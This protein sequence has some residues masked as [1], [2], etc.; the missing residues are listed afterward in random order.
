MNPTPL[1]LARAALAEVDAPRCG[2]LIDGEYPCALPA[3][4]FPGC[5]VE[6]DYHIDVA[7]LRAA[8]DEVDRLTPPEKVARWDQWETSYLGGMVSRLRAA[9]PPKAESDVLG[10]CSTVPGKPGWGWCLPTGRHDHAP[11]EALARAAVEQEARAQGWA[12]KP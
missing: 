11:T 9:T 7:H 4:H 5:D 3:G 12:V 8:L 6:P 10:W 1:Q 2:R